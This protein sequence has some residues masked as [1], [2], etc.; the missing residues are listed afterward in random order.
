MIRLF[1]SIILVFSAIPTTAKA[2]IAVVVNPENVLQ[3]MSRK[4]VINLFLG[5]HTVF[6]SG[7][8]ALP[9]DQPMSSVERTTF[10]KSLTG[11]TAAQINAHW[12]RLIFSGRATPPRVA[13]DA[14]TIIAMIAENRNAIAYMDSSHVN[15]LVKVV[16]TISN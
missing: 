7:S 12:A 4:E 9:L 5:H 15:S 6:P 14:S 8:P 16:L 13:P 11:K 3:T 10:Y 1:L 2:D